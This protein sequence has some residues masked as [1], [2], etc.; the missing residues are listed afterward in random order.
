MIKFSSASFIQIIGLL[1]GLFT[2]LSAAMFHTIDTTSPLLCTFSSK[3]QNRVMVEKGKIQKVIA[4]DEGRLSIFMEELSGQA[5]IC[6]R[7]QD[8]EDTTISVVTE[9]GLVQDLQ[10]TFIERLPEVVILTDPML[11]KQNQEEDVQEKA[12]ESHVLEK[13]SDI[14]MGNIPQGYIPCQIKHSQWKPKKGF[15]LES[16]AQ[17]EGPNEILKLYQVT[18]TTCKQ[19]TLSE[20]ELQCQGCCWVFLETNTILPKQKILGIIA[21]QK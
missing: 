12:A 8:P 21:V 9:T 7:D 17:L 19:K 13:I 3:Y 20:V 1:G 10:V 2:P 18:N 11:E 5:F 6:A 16:I 4:A 14:L 15:T